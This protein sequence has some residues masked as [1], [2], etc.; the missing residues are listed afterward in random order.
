MNGR[1]MRMQC[2]MLGLAIA[3]GGCP[4]SVESLITESDV[5]F[6]PR[7]LGAWEEVNGSDRA[8]IARSGRNGYAID[9][10]PGRTGGWFWESRDTLKRFEA[11]LGRLGDRLIL[12]VLVP[13]EEGAPKPDGEPLILL[14]FMSVLEIGED[15]VRWALIDGDSLTAA[16]RA[17][18]VRLAYTRSDNS[19]DS[20]IP[21]ELTLH[22]TTEELRAA[23]GLYLASPGA[24]REWSVFRRV[25]GARNTAP[26][27]THADSSGI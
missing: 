22:G 15:E 9:Y 6:D 16:L 7:L 21:A 14:H 11:R 23:L 8:V 5:T 26:P 3:L 12:G 25:R 18:R 4:F 24:L 19:D 10:G 2:G 13:P 1:H 20:R 27:S 17:G